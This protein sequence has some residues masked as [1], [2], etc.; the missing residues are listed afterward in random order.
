MVTNIFPKHSVLIKFYF[1]KYCIVYIEL[2]F[3]VYNYFREYMF[4]G[5]LF[6][7]NRNNNDIN[8]ITMKTDI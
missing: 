3:K 7:N 2:L 1:Q 5:L 8:I 6:E 4:F